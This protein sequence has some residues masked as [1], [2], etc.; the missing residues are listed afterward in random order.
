MIQV[1]IMTPQEQEDFAD[2]RLNYDA[3]KGCYIVTEQILNSEFRREKSV[4]KVETE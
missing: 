3:S 4:S 2:G 1:I